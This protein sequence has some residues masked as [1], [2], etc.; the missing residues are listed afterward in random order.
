MAQLP[1]VFLC[2][3]GHVLR[4]AGVVGN[5]LP[6]VLLHHLETGSEN[7]PRTFIGNV[8]DPGGVQVMWQLCGSSVNQLKY[9]FLKDFYK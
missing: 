1:S 2:G 3:D 4:W 8:L 6:L 7:I 9:L 5:N